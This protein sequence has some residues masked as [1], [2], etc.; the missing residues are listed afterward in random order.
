MIPIY[1]PLIEPYSKSA[2][3]AIE[4]SWISNY[5]IYIDLSSKL[6]CDILGVKYCIL[7]NNGTSA[8]HCLYKALKFKYPNISK[9]YIPN[10]VFVAPWNCG[11]QEYNLSVFEVM[12][13]NPKTLN[14]CTD[15]DYILSL[16]SNSAVVIVHNLGNIINVPRLQRIRPDIVFLEDN[17][18]GLFGK[19]ESKYSGSS[20]ITLCSAVSF[21]ANKTITTGEGGAFF[22]NDIDVYKYIKTFYSH[23][24]SE[25]RYVH[26]LIGT[27]YRMTNIQAA[28][29]YDQLNDLQNLLEKKNKIYTNYLKFVEKLGSVVYTLEIEDLTEHSQWMFSLFFKD[30]KFVYSHFENFMSQKNIQVRP[31][32]YDIR[33]HQQL[34]SINIKESPL[35]IHGFMLPS[36]P[37]LSELEQ[38][39]I[40]Q[41][42]QEYIQ[43][44]SN[45]VKI[46]EVKTCDQIY[47]FL[48]QPSLISHHF[49]YFNKRIPEN[50]LPN[51]L[52]T[53][54]LQINSKTIGYAH[55]DQEDSK[56]WVG[57]CILNG[58]HGKG[59]GTL[60]LK[61]IVSFADSNN[62]SLYLS[63][64]SDNFSA[65]K[66]YSK[67]G[68]NISNNQQNTKILFM[69]RSIT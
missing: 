46:M 54:I 21:Y 1:K 41:C 7:M 49:R 62:L 68:F 37:S 9:I 12:K 51:H 17:C 33:V 63:V 64:D 65:I 6:L 5:G 26:S 60:L 29:L 16:E 57:I 24:M 58:H 15:E 43:L 3:D 56:A 19:Y 13:M 48:A 36:Y 4:S 8:T 11:I 20:P 42:I 18:E 35:E 67:F 10:N 30:I 27:N 23:G 44:Y 66:L 2:K 39:F 25:T 31:I 59:Y 52:L 50:V 22:T 40:I 28:F 38:K 45:S 34:S 61:K 14:I 53:L 32:F 47:D 69:E 55:I